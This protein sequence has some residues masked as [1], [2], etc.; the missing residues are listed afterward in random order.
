MKLPLIS[1]FLFAGIIAGP[2][3]LDFISAEAVEK[4]R[5][6]DEIS[7][8]VIAFAAGSEL[9]LR[10]LRSRFRNIAWVTIGNILVV[11]LL[12]TLAVFL[13]ADFIPFI[14]DLPSMSRLAVSLLAGAILVARSPS[15]AIALI[16]ELRASGPFTKT[17]LGVTMITDVV[18]IIIF[19]V[20]SSIADAILT[21][22]IRLKRRCI[23]PA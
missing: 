20:N 16:N 10:E 2:F 14:Q 23:A 3:G 1:G 6:V 5:F 18:V 17:V 12:G 7:L 4:L 8:A 21:N 22:L 11:P 19:A 13:L 15:S 9:Y